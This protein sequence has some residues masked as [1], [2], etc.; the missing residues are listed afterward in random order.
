MIKGN[1]LFLL[2]KEV[3]IKREAVSRLC[4]LLSLEKDSEKK[5][6]KI[7]TLDDFT[8]LNVFQKTFMLDLSRIKVNRQF[9]EVC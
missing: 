7:K 9:Y 5:I 8:L 4:W 2:S 3:S 1:L 6:P